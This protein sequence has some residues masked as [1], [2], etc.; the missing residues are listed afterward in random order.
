MMNEEAGYLQLSVS[1]QQV[2]VQIPSASCNVMNSCV[3]FVR[4]D[5]YHLVSSS[6]HRYILALL[7]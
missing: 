7:V 2:L 3:V 6:H 5:G 4:Y 1:V